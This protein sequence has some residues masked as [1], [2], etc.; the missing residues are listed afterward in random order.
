[1]LAALDANGWRRQDTALYLSISRKVL[2]D[3]MRRYQ[4][5]YEDPEN[6]RK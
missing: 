4:I 3:K 5:F 2:W 6:S 1:V